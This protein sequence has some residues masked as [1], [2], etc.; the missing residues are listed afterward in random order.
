M[1]IRGSLFYSIVY[2]SVS[3]QNNNIYNK[4]CSM[5]KMEYLLMTNTNVYTNKI[6][7]T[8]QCRDQM[9]VILERPITIVQA[10]M[11]YGK[12][13][14]VR[15]FLK[16][17]EAMVLWVDLK[18]CAANRRWDYFCKVIRD[19][20]PDHQD[21]CNELESCGVPNDEETVYRIIDIIDGFQTERPMIYVID[22]FDL[23]CNQFIFLL[24]RVAAEHGYHNT[25]AVL[26]TRNAYSGTFDELIL[27]GKLAIIPHDV[28]LFHEEDIKNYYLLC[29]IDLKPEAVNRLMYLTEGWISALYLFLLQLARE[30]SFI[31]PSTLYEII[32]FG[33]FSQLAEKQID[34]LYHV[35]VLGDFSFQ[36]AQYI[37]A[38]EDDQAKETYQVLSSLTKANAFIHYNLKSEQYHIHQIIRL[39]LLKK[40]SRLPE[41]MQMELNHTWGSW[42]YKRQIYGQAIKY[43]IEC[44]EYISILNSIQNIEYHRLSIEDWPILRKFIKT[45][46]RDIMKKKLETAPLLFLFA[47]LVGDNEI[48]QE[49]KE[50]YLDNINASP[51]HHEAPEKIEANRKVIEAMEAY[52]DANKMIESLIQIKEPSDCIKAFFQLAQQNWTI[53]CFSPL[54]MF[55]NEAGALKKNIRQVKK[56]LKLLHIHTPGCGAGG[57]QIME[58]EWQLQKGNIIEAEILSHEGE[59][60]AF[61]EHELGNLIAAKII[62]LHITVLVDDE[63]K[64]IKLK[65]EIQQIISTC[66]YENFLLQSMVELSFTQNALICGQPEMTDFWLQKDFKRKICMTSYPMYQILYGKHLLQ[67][68]EYTKIIGYFQTMIEEPFY[69]R[70]MLFMVYTLIFMAAS[71]YQTGKKQ[72]AEL[73]LKRAFDIA[74]QDEVYLPF[75]EHIGQIRTIADNLYS[76]K[77]Y[78]TIMIHI[79]NL[80]VRFR[81]N[82]DSPEE[83]KTNLTNREKELAR[84]AAAGKTNREIGAELFIAQSTVK[85]SMVEIYKKLNIHKRQELLHFLDLFES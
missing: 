34:F 39:F 65:S 70:H 81:T 75:V 26:L 62:Q 19:H 28:F 32:D 47:F 24:L 83:T 4:I 7:I 50:F 17:K 42:F 80:A 68:R 3:V 72:K 57:G 20:F 76:S 10:P 12:T 1:K 61:Q 14:A 22:N 21:L 85:R 59:L 5:M 27:K 37:C 78:H 53:G 79:E 44:K 64:G 29:G 8:E 73:Y 9:P 38:A 67:N 52:N 36:Q 60:L 63:N 33:W 15:E 69:N 45:C 2:Y 66:P 71:K 56:L 58:A 16:D 35:S 43:Y 46:P 49:M 51:I 54:L 82:A 18:S 6:Y 31:I 25:H 23:V 84:L 77:P 11:G 74:D 30:E 41:S 40:V 13:V 48:Y 55:W